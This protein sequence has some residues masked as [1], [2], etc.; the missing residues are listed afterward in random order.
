MKMSLLTI[1]LLAAIAAAA[2][3]AYMAWQW[4]R[5]HERAELLERLIAVNWGDS[6]ARKAF[7]GAYVYY[8]PQADGR[9]KVL[10]SVRISRS[11]A[12]QGYQHEPRQIGTAGNP[13]EAVAKW[14]AVAWSTAGLTVGSGADAYL[15]PRN[16]LERHR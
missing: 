5:L 8:E 1:A 4:S 14:G 2:V 15:F 12:D 7:Y 11:S 6:E 3:G 10:L 16:E 9:L 13:E